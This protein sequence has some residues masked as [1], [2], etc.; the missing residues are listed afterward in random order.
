MPVG[1]VRLM[2]VLGPGINFWAHKNEPL[3]LA[4]VPLHY[5]N[6]RNVFDAVPIKRVGDLR[7]IKNATGADGV[8]YVTSRV[9][10][11]REYPQG[12]GRG[13][14]GAAAEPPPGLDG[15]VDTYRFED[16]EAMTVLK[17]E[18]QHFIDEMGW[19]RR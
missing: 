17:S 13:P 8:A 6:L 2:E 16:N 19:E 1:L 3:N 5:P 10:A 4:D 18:I 14:G 12:W 7:G 11:G 15:K 9:F